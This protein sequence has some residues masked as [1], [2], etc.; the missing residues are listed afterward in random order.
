MRTAYKVGLGGAAIGGLGGI[1]FLFA[2][3]RYRACMKPS[4]KDPTGAIVEAIVQ[5]FL[6]SSLDM[7]FAEWAA[8][9]G[10]TVAA[11]GL[12]VGLIQGK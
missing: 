9:A 2:R 10:L 3:E 1:V 8:L 5:P 7:L 4:V 12:T 6:C 11:G